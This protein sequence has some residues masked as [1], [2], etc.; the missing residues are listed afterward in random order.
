[1]TRNIRSVFYLHDFNGSGFLDSLTA[2]E[3]ALKCCGVTDEQSKS[4]FTDKFGGKI[5]FRRF[6]EIVEKLE[7]SKLTKILKLK[8][9]LQFFPNPIKLKTL[10][11]IMKS[12]GMSD[13]EINGF[14]FGSLGIEENS[15]DKIDQEEFCKK[16]T[17]MV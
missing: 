7:D 13:A 16:I 3:T 8:K 12:G 15:V 2:Y 1:M 6:S 11:F 5:D 10:K 4:T 17:V 9:Q 14:L